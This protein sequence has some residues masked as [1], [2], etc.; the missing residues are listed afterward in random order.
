M[1][2]SDKAAPRR[3]WTAKTLAGALL[4]FAL[5]IGASALFSL[6]AEPMPL[7]MRGQLAMWMVPPVWLGVLSGVYFFGSGLRAWL[8]LGGATLLTCGALLALRAGRSSV[9]RT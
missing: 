8:W 2:A 9:P 1:G 4:G 6:L 3:D 7:P 5:A